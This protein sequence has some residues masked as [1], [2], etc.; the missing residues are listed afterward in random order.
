MDREEVKKA[1]LKRLNWEDYYPSDLSYYA[2]E[3]M[4]RLEEELAIEGV[5]QQHYQHKRRE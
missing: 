2:V 3:A 4:K 1:G 5:P